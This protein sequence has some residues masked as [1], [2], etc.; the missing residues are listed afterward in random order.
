MPR[1][2]AKILALLTLSATAAIC[3]AQNAS[4]EAPDT[5]P[6]SSQAASQEATPLNNSPMNSQPAPIERGYANTY[7]SNT[8]ITKFAVGD[9]IAPRRGT[10][11][12]QPAAGIFLRVARNSAVRAVALGG[13]NTEL[14]VERGIA[15][16][17]IHH[18]VN[19]AQILV[20]LPG[21]QTTLIK[22][23]F[24]TFN[25]QTNTIRVL[26]GEAYAYPGNNTNQKPI[27]VKED[28]AVVFNGPDIKAFEFDPF[29]ARIDLIPYPPQGGTPSEY[30]GYGPYGLAY[31]GYPYYYGDPYFYG[32]YPFGFGLGF[33]GG[34]FYGGGF[35]GGGFRGGGRR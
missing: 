24:Y 30:Y 27:K 23:G 4:P 11:N 17:N 16:I 15:N 34:G 14:R 35:Y 20:D 21:G 28:H 8:Y 19:H 12:A 29:E 26:K 5:A 31:G 7:G 33:Y 6:D 10:I 1:Q 22:D 2:I 25:A 32:Y 9:V 18:P 13:E 3:V